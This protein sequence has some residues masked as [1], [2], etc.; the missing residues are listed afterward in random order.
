MKT[1][2]YNIKMATCI[3]ASLF[4]SVV[5]SAIPGMPVVPFVP[6]PH[7]ENDPAFDSSP[8]VVWAL[9]HKLLTR[10]EMRKDPLAIQAIKDEGLGIRAR[11]VWDDS[12]VM[13]KD[14]RLRLARNKGELIHVASVMA[15]ASIKF[16]ESPQKRK[17]KARV[18]FRGDAVKDSYGAAA[19][20]GELYPHPQTCSR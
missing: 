18:V 9:I 11:G 4:P 12:T 17:H 1:G 20:F 6:H 16:W 5:F 15:I 10:E 7:V 2:A 13:E 14:E 3:L 8:S 19:R